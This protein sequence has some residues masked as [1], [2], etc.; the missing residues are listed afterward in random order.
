LIN[1]KHSLLG[2]CYELLYLAFDFVELITASY[3]FGF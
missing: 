1:L 3:K 2:L